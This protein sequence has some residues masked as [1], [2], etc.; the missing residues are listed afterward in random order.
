MKHEEDTVPPAPMGQV[1]Q[2]VRALDPERAKAAALLLALVTDT[3]RCMQLLEALDK[4]AKDESSYE[5]GLPLWSE[6]QCARL[7]EVLYRWACGAL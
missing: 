6:P 5:Y 1:D 4:A 7:R 3:P 2:G